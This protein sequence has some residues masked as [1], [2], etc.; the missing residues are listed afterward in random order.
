MYHFT[1]TNPTFNFGF[2]AKSCSVVLLFN[3]VYLFWDVFSDKM[4][5]A[6]HVESSRGTW[7]LWALQSNTKS[8]KNWCLLIYSLS[9]VFD[10]G[11]VLQCLSCFILL[12]HHGKSSFSSIPLML[13][14]G[15]RPCFFQWAGTVLN[16][17]CLLCS[18]AIL[19]SLLVNLNLQVCA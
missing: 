2:L 15:K 1:L 7:A 13:K 19:S 8:Q 5:G 4:P 10:V 11:H 12:T 3:L 16:L 17:I 18:T 14:L 6:L 9:A